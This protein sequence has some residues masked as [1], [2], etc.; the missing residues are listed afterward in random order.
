M[1][2]AV[3]RSKRSK[4][5]GSKR[6]H[7]N[8]L[9]SRSLDANQEPDNFT[10]QWSTVTFKTTYKQPAMRL[11]VNPRYPS[12]CKLGETFAVC[13]RGLEAALRQ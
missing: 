8:I 12:G 1:T 4:R 7:A 10:A 5:C 6:T 2:A 13:E 3:F 9:I 11:K